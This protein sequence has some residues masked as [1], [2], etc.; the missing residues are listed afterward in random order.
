MRVRKVRRLAL[1]SARR[2]VPVTDALHR[3][4]LRSYDRVLGR[5]LADLPLGRPRSSIHRRRGVGNAE[6]RRLWTTS[7]PESGFVLHLVL[8]V[9]RLL[10]YLEDRAALE[11]LCR[12]VRKAES[13]AIDVFGPDVP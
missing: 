2:E 8:R 13:L 4:A 11:T 10:V 5:D 12:V 3:P 7:G 9:G 6:R 1:R